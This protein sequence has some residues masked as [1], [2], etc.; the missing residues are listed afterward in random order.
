[1]TSLYLELIYLC[2][3][4]SAADIVPFTDKSVYYNSVVV[5]EFIVKPHLRAHCIKCVNN[6]QYIDIIIFN[7]LVSASL[8]AL[9]T[10]CW[11]ASNY[12]IIRVIFSDL[13]DCRRENNSGVPLSV[14]VLWLVV[15][16]EVVLVA[17][18]V[19]ILWS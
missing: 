15:L 5:L 4:I 9:N 16:A 12:D 3:L 7:F 17:P 8:S 11:S 1:M 2:C 6:S 14:I 19:L 18:L 13:T 10:R